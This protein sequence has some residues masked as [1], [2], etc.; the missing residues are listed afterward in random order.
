MSGPV[1]IIVCVSK[2]DNRLIDCFSPPWFYWVAVIFKYKQLL[3]AEVIFLLLTSFCM[4][5]MFVERFR[6]FY[7]RRAIW[8]CVYLCK[9]IHVWLYSVVLLTSLQY[10]ENSF[11]RKGWNQIVSNTRFTL[12]L[13][14][15]YWNLPC[16]TSRTRIRY[17]VVL[18]P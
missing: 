11:Q 17:H 13:C 5:T 10:D 8:L 4:S 15:L 14:A 3:L 2:I 9:R 16:V 12:L 1:I 7:F 18:F 6:R